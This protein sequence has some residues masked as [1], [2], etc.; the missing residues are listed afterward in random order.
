MAK[1][2]AY[3]STSLV[4]FLVIGMASY[5]RYYAP[6]GTF[7]NRN[8]DAATIVRDVH[9]LNELATVQYGVK[10]ADAEGKVE[11]RVDLSA[12][13]QYDVV[14]L[15]GSAVTLRLPAPRVTAVRVAMRVEDA[16]PDR[17]AILRKAALDMGIL[18]DAQSR[19]EFAVRQ[20]LATQGVSDVRFQ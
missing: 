12:L 1:L 10:T 2:I 9:E 19:A 11:A 14:A 16:R 7:L 17:E 4:L 8:L 6:A 13:T 15:Q 5:F 3:I 18:R 20:F